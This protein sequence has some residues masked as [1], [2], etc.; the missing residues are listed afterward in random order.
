MEGIVTRLIKTDERGSEQW[1]RNLVGFTFF[2][3][4]MVRQTAEGGF[5][6]AGSILYGDVRLFKTDAEGNEQWK[7]TFGGNDSNYVNSI[8]QTRDGGYI[9]AGTTGG[10]AWMVKVDA[11]GHEQWNKTFG[12]GG[13]DSADSVLQTPDGGFILAGKI[14]TAKVPDFKDQIL[15]ENLDAWIIKTDLHG[16]LEWSRTYGGLRTDRASSVLQTVDGG[17]ILVGSTDSNGLEDIWMTKIANTERGTSPVFI[18]VPILLAAIARDLC[19]LWL[20]AP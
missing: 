17:Y 4:C 12:L 9:F 7:K 20:T 10:D 15:Y 13:Y 19:T 18:K 5:I 11:Q 6:L 1:S 2:P 16:N 3:H 8:M 14:D